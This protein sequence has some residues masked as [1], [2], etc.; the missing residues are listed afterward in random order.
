M[1]SGKAPGLQREQVDKAVS[2]L[3][4]YI[5]SQKADSKDLLEDEE[6]LYLVSEFTRFGAKSFCISASQN[7]RV[8]TL[9]NIALKKTPQPPKNPSPIRL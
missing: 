1:A 5:G 7:L 4:K 6:Y 9:Q 2:A 3:L 8:C